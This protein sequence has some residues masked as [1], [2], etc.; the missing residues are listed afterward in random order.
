MALQANCSFYMTR[1][2]FRKEETRVAEDINNS[3]NA[4]L[5]W[6]KNATAAHPSYA[7]CHIFTLCQCCAEA[8]ADS[9]D[10]L[11]ELIVK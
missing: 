11:V 9:I 6:K 4:A 8:E 2:G 5:S 10:L 7:H 3:A 1:N